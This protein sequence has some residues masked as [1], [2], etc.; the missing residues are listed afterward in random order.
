MSQELPD[1]LKLIL[2]DE[3]KFDDDIEQ[4]VKTKFPF[5][6]EILQQEYK[7]WKNQ[8][9]TSSWSLWKAIFNEKDYLVL[10]KIRVETCKPEC[11]PQLLGM[12]D[13]NDLCT[14]LLQHHNTLCPTQQFD[15]NKTLWDKQSKFKKQNLKLL[16]GVTFQKVCKKTAADFR[17]MY[18]EFYI[19][20]MVN[21]EE[22]FL[23]FDKTIRGILHRVDEC[24]Q[25][26]GKFTAFFDITK[27]IDNLFDYVNGTNAQ[28]QSVKTIQYQF[29]ARCQR[30]HANMHGEF[31][32]AVWA[33]LLDLMPITVT[34]GRLNLIPI[35]NMD[36]LAEA[37]CKQELTGEGEELVKQIVNLCKKK[38]T[39]D[40]VVVMK[41]HI[42]EDLRKAELK[43]DW[44]SVLFEGKHNILDP[45]NKTSNPYL[46]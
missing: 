11:N 43:D 31:V 13:L 20:L 5:S 40:E 42:V 30:L 7:K 6:W 19:P 28:W 44:S 37:I 17:N 21:S 8:N 15:S 27:N 41:E 18:K 46:V 34:E 25:G 10:E 38:M 4:I 9:P 22:I 12:N 45:W 2:E 24:K 33:Y 23:T 29:W 36:P 3:K 1:F 26:K 32:A 39:E 14:I 35:A 16:E